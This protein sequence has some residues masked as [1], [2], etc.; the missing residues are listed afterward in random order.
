MIVCPNCNHTNP[1]GATQC[2]ACY[3]ALPEMMPCPNCG[4]SVQTDAVFCGQ[5]GYHLQPVTPDTPEESEILPTQMSLSPDAASQ[6][7]N[8]NSEPPSPWDEESSP[9]EPET[10]QENPSISP[11]T[12]EFLTP[13][14][15][16]EPVAEVT[17]PIPESE[18]EVISPTP[19]PAPSPVPSVSPPMATQ[20]QVQTASLLHVQTQKSIDIPNNLNVIHIGK[21]NEQIPPDI[22]V[23][24]FGNS[25]VVSRIHADIRVEGDT[26]YLEDM[27]SS[28]GTYVNHTPLPSGNRHCLRQGD[29]ISLGKGDLVTFIF[30]R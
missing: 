22:D 6:P 5:C 8:L 11:S 17:P 27:G 13:E 23:S 19:Q 20:L 12:S 30:Q 14:P 25:E 1:E 9:D 24:G 7:N 28:N 15:E 26:Y 4:L 18:P 16:S 3:T 29:R 2:E 10:V 21:P